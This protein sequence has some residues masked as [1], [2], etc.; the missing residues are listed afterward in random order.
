MCRAA[1]F[2]GRNCLRDG[3]GNDGPVLAV[4]PPRL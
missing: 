3:A 4:Q 2:S 1:A